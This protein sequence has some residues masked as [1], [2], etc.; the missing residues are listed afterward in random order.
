[1]R[2]ARVDNNQPL[3]VKALKRIGA[4]VIHTHQLKNAFDILVA[5]RGQLYAV[6]IKDAAQLPNK[7]FDMTPEDREAYLVDK[8]LTPGE[9]ECRRLL[10]AV[11][12]PYYIVWSV[13]SVIEAIGANRPF[14]D[15]PPGKLNSGTQAKRG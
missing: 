10:L 14:F 12:V 4:V 3:I 15:Q 1:M 6:E 8:M 7:F 5:F 11:G 2:K 13:D 9:L